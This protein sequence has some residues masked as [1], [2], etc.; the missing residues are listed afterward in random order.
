MLTRDEKYFAKK[1]LASIKIVSESILK[2]K[3]KYSQETVLK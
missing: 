3:I 1:Y 2:Y